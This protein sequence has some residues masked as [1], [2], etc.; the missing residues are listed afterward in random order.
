[1]RLAKPPHSPRHAAPRTA[2][3]S[4]TPASPPP[5]S[6]KTASKPPSFLHSATAPSRR[7]TTVRH[8]PRPRMTHPIPP[9]R[10]PPDAAARLVSLVLASTRSARGKGGARGCLPRVVVVV[11]FLPL[12]LFFPTSPLHSLLCIVSLSLCLF[13][14]PVTRSLPYSA[15]Y[16]LVCDCT[17]PATPSRTIVC[18]IFYSHPRSCY[19]LSLP[20]RPPFST[21][22]LFC[23]I[24]SS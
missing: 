19:F 21:S 20:L 17:F 14:L 1:M 5:T 4:P 8:P 6:P 7:L 2:L 13:R 11:R 23:S 10:L 12:N 24:S 16:L 18:I 22:T 15:Q 3:R 9:P